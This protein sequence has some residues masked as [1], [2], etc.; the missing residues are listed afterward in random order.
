MH[1]LNE[2]VRNVGEGL[3]SLGKIKKKFEKVTKSI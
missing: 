2:S 3:L 1:H